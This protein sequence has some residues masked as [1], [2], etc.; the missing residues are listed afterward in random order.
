MSGRRNREGSNLALFGSFVVGIF[1]ALIVGKLISNATNISFG[2]AVFFGTSFF[3]IVSYCLA[4]LFYVYEVILTGLTSIALG[5]LSGMLVSNV[6]L[7]E[8]N[9]T[10]Q[11]IVS[12]V[13]AILLFFAAHRNRIV[14]RLDSYGERDSYSKYET[15]Q[16]TYHTNQK[17]SSDPEFDE[18]LRE[19]QEEFEDVARNM[20]RQ[21][22]QKLSQADSYSDFENSYDSQNDSPVTEFVWF[23][24]CE[25]EDACNKRRKEL[26]KIYHPDQTS[27]DNEMC[28]DIQ[29][30]YEAVM[31][32]GWSAK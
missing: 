31:A 5:V 22:Y 29:K 8:P 26:M 24:G 1:S 28:A 9:T 11:A 27:G 21:Y 7:K 25:G 13:V 2:V 19:S 4:S 12:I 30:E 16:D 6:L 17:P 32:N 3:T 14:N 20:K 15:Y 10:A 23:A 18:F